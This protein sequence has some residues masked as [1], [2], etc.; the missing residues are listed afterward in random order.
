MFVRSYKSGVIVHDNWTGPHVDSRFGRISSKS[1]FETG[2]P[3]QA[4]FFR[5]NPGAPPY[6]EDVIKPIP[7]GVCA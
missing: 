7:M 4:R 3:R 2:R 1:G 5:D 6:S